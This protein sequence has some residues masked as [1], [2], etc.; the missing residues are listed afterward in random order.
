[1]IFILG[2]YMYIETSTAPPNANAYMY[3][4]WYYNIGQKCVQFFY[5]MY[6][7]Q[8]GQLNV[9][10]RYRKSRYLYRMFSKTGNQNN[11]WHMGQASVVRSK[12]YFQVK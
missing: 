5:H 9:Y 8:I 7:Q 12:T 11:T 4:P 3:S 2:H 6:G 10:I 1:M